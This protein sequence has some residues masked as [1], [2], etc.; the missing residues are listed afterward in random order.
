[1]GAIKEIIKSVGEV[2]GTGN[3]KLK[4]MLRDLGY[5]ESGYCCDVVTSENMFQDS[6]SVVTGWVYVRDENVVF[7]PKL[8]DYVLQNI[9]GLPGEETTILETFDS[10][11]QTEEFRTHMKK[12]LREYSKDSFRDYVEKELDNQQVV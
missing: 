8:D 4:R 10:M 9:D 12:K 3:Y 1:M 6:N 7:I 11:I 5:E 2:L